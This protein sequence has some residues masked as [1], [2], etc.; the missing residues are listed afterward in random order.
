MYVEIAL[1]CLLPDAV[2]N[3][4]IFTATHPISLAPF[5]V[6]GKCHA[7][8]RDMRIIFQICARPRLKSD[9]FSYLAMR[10]KMTW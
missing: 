10:V 9:L 4:S 6:L 1:L 5:Y 7:S 8:S 3:P 2:G